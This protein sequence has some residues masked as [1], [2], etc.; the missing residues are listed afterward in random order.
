MIHIDI[1]VF[2]SLSILLD[3]SRL[4]IA[5]LT[6]LISIVGQVQIIIPFLLITGLLL[7]IIDPEVIEAPVLQLTPVIKLPGRI[8]RSQLTLLNVLLM[9]GSTRMSSLQI[10]VLLLN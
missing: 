9:V 10:Y 1:V 2:V 7:L 4:C 5:V 3:V 6:L 8:L